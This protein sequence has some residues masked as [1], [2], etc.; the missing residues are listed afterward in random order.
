VFSSI[1]SSSSSTASSIILGLSH[2]LYIIVL[3]WY[4]CLLS[5]AD[6]SLTRRSLD[7]TDGGWRRLLPTGLPLTTSTSSHPSPL[8]SSAKCI[9]IASLLPPPRPPPTCLPTPS[10]SPSPSPGTH[11]PSSSSSNSSH[12]GL[13]LLWP[14]RFTLSSPLTSLP[15]TPMSLPMAIMTHNNSLPSGLSINL[16]YL[17]VN[18]STSSFTATSSVLEPPPLPHSGHPLS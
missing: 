18:P 14:P 5:P 13:P 9:Q 11:T 3:V 6:C 16:S 12:H 1:R 2:S 10:P 4:A 7:A 17:M 15:T 8:L